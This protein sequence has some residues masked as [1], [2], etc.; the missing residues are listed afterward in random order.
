MITYDCYMDS[1]NFK[2]HLKKY[3]SNENIDKL[4]T[5]LNDKQK[6]S[7]IIIDEEKIDKETIKKIYPTLIEH[8]FVKNAFLYDKELELGK[9]LLFE[10]GAFY[11]LEPC[12]ILV[13]HFL[14]P[15]FQKFLQNRKTCFVLVQLVLLLL[16]L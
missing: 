15:H 5:S 7:C 1:E 3:L 12:S 14:N 13:S 10:I 16:F 11:I 9:S 6:Y 4:I 2:Q 8:P